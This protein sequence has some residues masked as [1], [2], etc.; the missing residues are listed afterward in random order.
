MVAKNPKRY[1]SLEEINQFVDLFLD[2]PILSA[3]EEFRELYYKTY[4][5]S[6]GYE[7]VSQKTSSILRKYNALLPKV[8][9]VQHEMY[10]ASM[11]K[12]DESLKANEVHYNLNYN[13]PTYHQIRLECKNS[14]KATVQLEIERISTLFLME[15]IVISKMKREP[16]FFNDYQSIFGCKF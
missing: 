1:A 11:A 5:A 4:D 7:G 13:N 14:G 16:V 10:H 3:F 9:G 15:G 6:L 12:I 8:L 2:T